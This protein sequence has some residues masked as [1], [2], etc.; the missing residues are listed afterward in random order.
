M[1]VLRQLQRGD[2]VHQFGAGGQL[3][4]GVVYGRPGAAWGEELSHQ[5][6]PCTGLQQGVTFGTSG[7]IL[8]AFTGY[9]FSY[10]AHISDGK[11]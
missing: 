7:R 6:S 2:G 10:I 11:I 4:A 3:G 5:T 9:E 1:A 8:S